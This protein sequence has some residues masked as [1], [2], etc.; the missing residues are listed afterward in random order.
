MV[1]QGP[2]NGLDALERTPKRS[3]EGLILGE[4]CDRY[5]SNDNHVDRRL[6]VS[7]NKIADLVK[8]LGEPKKYI[9][10]EPKTFSFASWQTGISIERYKLGGITYEIMRPLGMKGARAHYALYLGKQ[11]FA[12]GYK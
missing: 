11:M 7:F 3:L 4:V 9:E 5:V 1:S 12:C 10:R 6:N 2:R 8:N